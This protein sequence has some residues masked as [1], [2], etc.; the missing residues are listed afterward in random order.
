[1]LLVGVCT[2]VYLVIAGVLLVCFDGILFLIGLIVEIC[3]YCDLLFC[4]CDDCLT[5]GFMLCY[6]CVWVVFA[7]F[8]A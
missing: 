1:M 8:V 4:V 2:V 7:L 3:V 6:C 5:R